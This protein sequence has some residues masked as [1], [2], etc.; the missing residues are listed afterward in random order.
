MKTNRQQISRTQWNKQK[1]TGFHCV[2]IQGVRR[3]VAE[4]AVRRATTDA[5]TQNKDS[6][7]PKVL[8]D[9]TM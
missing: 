4:N 7:E 8:P 1:I 3:A 5:T 6:M 2:L 9:E